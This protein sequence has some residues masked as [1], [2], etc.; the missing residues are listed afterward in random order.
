MTQSTCFTNFC[1]NLLV[2]AECFYHFKGLILCNT[3]HLQFHQNL[4]NQNVRAQFRKSSMDLLHPLKKNGVLGSVYVLKKYYC[5]GSIVILYGFC[6]KS[7]CIQISSCIKV[8][9]SGGNLEGTT[10]I[11]KLLFMVR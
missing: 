11:F 7:S 4:K 3:K 10:F 5:D 2:G 1:D 8:I 6:I 9:N